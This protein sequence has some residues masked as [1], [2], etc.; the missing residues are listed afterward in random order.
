MN[1]RADLSPLLEAFFTQ[2]LMAQRKVSAH[3]ISSYRDT[4]RLLLKFA[5]RPLVPHWSEH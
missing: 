3:T 4:F 1:T 5:E 2:R